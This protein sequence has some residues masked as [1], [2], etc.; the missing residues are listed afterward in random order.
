MRTEKHI[1]KYNNPHYK[2]LDDYC[3]MSKN[4]YNFAN[5]HIRQEFVKN[6]KVISYE[7]LDKLMK[8]E[9]EGFDYRNMPSA[10]ASQQCLKILSD[11]WKSFLKASKDY[12]KNPNKYS[13]K[14]KLPNYKKKNGRNL[15]V[16]TSQQAKIKDSFINF[17]K[18][19]NGFK[20]K[21][22]LNKLQQ[23]RILPRYQHFIVEVVYRIDK[24]EPKKDNGLYLGIDLGIDNFATLGSNLP[25]FKPVIIN[26][27]SIK[28]FNKYYNKLSSKYKE[29]A[30]RMN[31]LDYTNRLNRLT[32][33]RNNKVSDYIHKASKSI[34]DYALSYGINTIIVGNNK[35]WKQKSKMSKK[36]NQSFVGIPHKQFIDK[37]VYKAES[38]GLNVIITEESYTSGTS[39]IDNEEPIKKFYNKSRRVFRGLF[40]SNSGIKINSDLNGVYQIIKKVVPKVFDN[41]IE[42][43]GLHPIKVDII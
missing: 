20:I 26:G 16:F 9:N 23:V 28:S 3:F 27:K 21:T 10:Q 6:K 40:I 18:K 2:L 29:I 33:K 11:M 31:D 12:K 38:V 37:I 13:G 32:M 41:G 39:F 36:V 35:N 5:Y 22:K 30:K 19:M 17:P 25:N 15:L 34:I 42:G 14:P 7:K 1:I 43:V 4:L 8:I 24:V